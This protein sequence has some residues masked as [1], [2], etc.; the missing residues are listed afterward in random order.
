[1]QWRELSQVLLRALRRHSRS[2]A[3]GPPDLRFGIDKSSMF[4]CRRRR[5]RFSAALPTQALRK[6]CGEAP[7]SASKVDPNDRSEA[8]KSLSLVSVGW[9]RDSQRLF[10]PGIGENHENLSSLIR[11]HRPP[12]LRTGNFKVH[13]K[14]PCLG[15]RLRPRSR[16][17]AVGPWPCLSL[18]M[19]RV[20]QA[21][22]EKVDES[23]RRNDR[24]E[25]RSPRRRHL[26]NS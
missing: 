23:A 16:L 17:P 5:R 14:R 26:R 9:C 24:V 20:W 15:P 18:E 8:R 6:A 1:M 3:R 10:P 4:R 25:H 22:V 7:G 11:S 19:A 21:T 12:S 13:G 2:L